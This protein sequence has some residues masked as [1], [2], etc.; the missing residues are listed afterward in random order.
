MKTKKLWVDDLCPAPPGWIWAKNARQAIARLYG[1]GIAELS[2]DHDLGDRTEATGYVVAAWLEAQAAAGRWAVVPQTI[3]TH[4]ANPPGAANIA[5]AAAAI[6]RM[7][8]TVP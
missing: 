5:A 3:R 7:R 2:L 4:S 6:E 1:G 8:E